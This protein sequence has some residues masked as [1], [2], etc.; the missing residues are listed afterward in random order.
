MSC[1]LCVWRCPL[2]E[3]PGLARGHDDRPG[4]SGGEG[5]GEREDGERERWERGESHEE[6]GE[7]VLETCFQYEPEI[8]ES[9]NKIID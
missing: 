3:G 2:G 4:R 6:E 7:I 5:F 9:D 1:R 8:L